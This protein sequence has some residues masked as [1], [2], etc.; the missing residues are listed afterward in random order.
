MVKIKDVKTVTK[1][2]GEEFYCLIV[3]GG[4]QP[5][6]SDKTGR[7]YFTTR[8]A[9]VPTTFDLKTCKNIIG[10]EFEGEVRKVV[11]EPYEYVI[12]DTGEIINLSHRWEFIDEGQKVLQDHLVKETETIN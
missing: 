6:I 9:T 2:N 5:V 11:C 12:E 8:T 3:E 1:S 7:M 4:V 10:S